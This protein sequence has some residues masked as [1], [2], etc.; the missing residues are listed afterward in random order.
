MKQVGA[1]ER[2]QTEEQLKIKSK[3]D[4]NAEIINAIILSIS[5]GVDTKKELLERAIDETGSTRRLVENVI[6]MHTGGDYSKG[7]RWF[8][9]RTVKNTKKYEL[10]AEN[11]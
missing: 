5:D 8:I 9:K 11:T 1:E 3:L 6:R 7:A 2:K 10:L 4:K